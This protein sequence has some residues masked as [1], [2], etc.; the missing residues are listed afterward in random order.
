MTHEETYTFGFRTFISLA[1]RAQLEFSR[2]NPI[3]DLIEN[4][5]V[6]WQEP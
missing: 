2:G 3:L 4:T 6:V 1:L 5:T